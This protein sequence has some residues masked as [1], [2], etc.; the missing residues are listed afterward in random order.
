MARSKISDESA[1]VW[2]EQV[3][4][5]LSGGNAPDEAVLGQMPNLL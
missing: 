1:K 4:E 2:L 3:L 5:A